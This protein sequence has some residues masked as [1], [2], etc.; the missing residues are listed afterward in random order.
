MMESDAELEQA[1]YAAFAREA[2]PATL[3][4]GVEER[5]G[6]DVAGPF[7]LKPTAGLNGAPARCPHHG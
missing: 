2:A 6:W 4:S 5:L 3:M 1:L 7:P